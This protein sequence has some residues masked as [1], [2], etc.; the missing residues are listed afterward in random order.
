MSEI[1]NIDLTRIIDDN[2]TICFEVLQ[3]FHAF[4][5]YHKLTSFPASRSD[6]GLRY[7]PLA[8][9]SLCMA[10]FASRSFNAARVLSGSFRKALRTNGRF[11]HEGYW[12]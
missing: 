9:V 5:S 3:P 8:R 2:L 12:K 1:W 4:S 7:L 10:L 6:L 11:G